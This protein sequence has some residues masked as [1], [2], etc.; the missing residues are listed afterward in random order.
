[1]GLCGIMKQEL[2]KIEVHD[3]WLVACF[4]YPFL[5]DT[6]FWD[7]PLEREEF[8]TREESLTRLM[9]GDLRPGGI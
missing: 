5:R 4:L 9:S 7:D 3:L 8:R 1:M 6:K 2:K